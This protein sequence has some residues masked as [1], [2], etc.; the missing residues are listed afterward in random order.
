MQNWA[1]DSH[2]S[3]EEDKEIGNATPIFVRQIVPSAPEEV[4]AP[5]EPKK[6]YGPVYQRVRN[7]NGDFVITNVNI[8]EVVVPVP[9]SQ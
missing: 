8:K 2:D 9:V 4:K 5:A 6:D 1:D 7:Q 3:D